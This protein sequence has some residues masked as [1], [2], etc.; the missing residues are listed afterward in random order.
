M[1]PLRVLLLWTVALASAPAQAQEF[2]DRVDQALTVSAWNDNVR[3]RVS[4]ILDLEG[5]YFQQPP[6][7]LVDATGN[8]LFNPRLS[9]FLDAQLGP[10]VY[11]FAQSRFDRGF[12]P[13]DGA[14]EA[15]ADEYAL[16]LTPWQ[17]GRLNLQVGKF[18]TVVGT[19]VERHLSWDNPFVTAPLPYSNRT[20]ISDAEAPAS[21]TE[22]VKGPVGAR[23]EYNPLIWGPSYT[24]GAA[25]SGRIGKLD[26]AA[27]LKNAALSSHP[28]VW[29]ATDLG[30]D[31]PTAGGRLGFRP[32]PMWTFGLSAS[33]GR[34]LAPEAGPTLPA[35]RGIGHYHQR[36]LGQ[37]IAFAWHHFQFWAEFYEARFEVP[38]VGNADTFAYYLE[39]K[40]KFT[41]QLFG[42]LR[43][44]QQF[45]GTVRTPEDG[46]TSWGRDTWRSDLALSYRLTAHAQIK[47]QYSLQHEG[48]AA[49]DLSHLAAAQFTVR[50]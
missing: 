18:A 35:G 27:E 48:A 24:T 1:R 13:S 44:N 28:E 36:L 9:L 23:Y 19:W 34:Y 46:S 33:D 15:R 14:A 4:G 16:R 32:N 2:L 37:D 5:Y 3:A 41:P 26:Y 40:Y 31:H 10:H 39:T 21:V 12:D 50:F 7:D 29:S 38:R 43:W 45:F 8:A 25:V 17:D 47:V 20:A 49:R 42:A 11:V 22:F 6:P 30:F